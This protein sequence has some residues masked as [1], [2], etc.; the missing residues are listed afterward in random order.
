V[1]QQAVQFGGPGE[2][3]EEQEVAPRGATGDRAPR[4][5]IPF[6]FCI[7]PSVALGSCLRVRK[8]S[9]SILGA[10]GPTPQS[11]FG[12]LFRTKVPTEFEFTQLRTGVSDVEKNPTKCTKPPRRASC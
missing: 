10:K 12:R 3:G 5:S 8:D 2:E 7:L 1:F 4:R 9:S 6:L 11:D